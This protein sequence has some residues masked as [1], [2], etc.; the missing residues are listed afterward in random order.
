MLCPFACT[1]LSIILVVPSSYSILALKCL[2]FTGTAVII[3]TISTVPFLSYYFNGQ[4]VAQR[5]SNLATD[6][7]YLHSD[8]LGSTVETTGYTTTQQ[9]YL[10]YGAQRTTEEVAAAYRYTG[11]RWEEAIGLY[12]YDARWYDPELGRFIQPDGVV[13]GPANPQ[14][15]NRYSYGLN[16]PVKYVDPSGHSAESSSGGAGPDWPTLPSPDVPLDLVKQYAEIYG[17]PWQVLAG[18]LGSEIGM[19][20][21]WYDRIGD[22]LFV[23][24][25]IAYGSLGASALYNLWPNPGPGIGNVHLSTARVVSQY[26]ADKYASN[27]AMQ[28]DMHQMQTAELGMVLAFTKINVQAAAACLRYLADYRFGENGSPSLADHS[29]ISSWTLNDA[30]AVWHGYRY[31]VEGVSPGA[32]GFAMSTFQQRE[33]S[34]D[35]MVEAAGGKGKSGSMNGAIPYFRYYYSY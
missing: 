12:D 33:L 32:E 8:H 3:T 27:G 19:D 7:T 31:G 10:P 2:T 30:V 35:L 24:T 1:Y 5:T 28:L 22:M 20:T 11:Q 13:P 16:N 26:M 14:A 15:L 4:L 18:L 21:V 23:F 17:I 34:F 29:N 25:P 9:L 6:V